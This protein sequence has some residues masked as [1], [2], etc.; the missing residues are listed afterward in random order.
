MGNRSDVNRKLRAKKGRLKYRLQ[1]DSLS[2]LYNTRNERKAL[3]RQATG[4]RILKEGML[5][6]IRLHS[7]GDAYYRRLSDNPKRH[8]RRME[9]DEA[10]ILFCDLPS[11]HAIMSKMERGKWQYITARS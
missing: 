2:P 9:E 5:E 10:I 11:V 3:L 4:Q 7:D 1:P 6:I 8:K